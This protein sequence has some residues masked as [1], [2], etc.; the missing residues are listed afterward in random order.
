MT[1]IPKIYAFRIAL[2]WRHFANYFVLILIPVI[3][4]CSLA[5]FH[6]VRLIEKDAAK[7]NDVIMG[8]FTEQTDTAFNALKTN[9]IHMLSTSNL[10][11]LLK[12]AN[13]SRDNQQRTE[14]IHSLREQLNNLQSNELVSKAFLYFVNYDLMVDVETYTDKNYYFDFRYPLDPDERSTF[15]SNLTDKKMMDFIVTPASSIS[16]LMSYPFNTS[17]PEVYLVVTVNEERL[18]DQISISEKWVTGT[19]IVSNKGVVISQTS[20]LTNELKGLPKEALS[21]SNPSQ[22]LITKE[23]AISLVQSHFDENWYY[24]SM[25]DLATLMKPA[26][27]TRTI[28]WVFLIFFIVVGALVSYY[29]SRRL[30]RPIMEIKEGLKLHHATSDPIQNVGNEFD[31]I[32]RFSQLIMKENKQLSQQVNGMVP[33]VQ[34][35]FV[36]KMLLGEYRDALSIEFYAR[37]IDFPYNHQAE[38]TVLCISFHY[39]SPVYEQ[40]SETSKSFLKAELKEKI[41]QLMPFNSWLCQTKPGMIACVFHQDSSIYTGPDEAAQ[42]IKLVLSPYSQYFKTT[43]GIGKTV[44]VIEELHESYKQATL[45]LQRRG[46]H[47]EVEI[48]NSQNEGDTAQYESFLSVQ[49]VTRIMNQFKI[50]EYDKLL[51]SAFDMLEEGIRINATAIQAKYLCSDILNTWIHAVESERNDF[52]VPLY[53]SLFEKMNR[54]M[55]WN[56]LKNCF[57]EIHHV[58]FPEVETEDRGKKFT[59]ILAYIHEN[60]HSELSIEYFAG[61]LHMSSGHFSRTFKEEVG[62][63][64]VEYIAKYRLMKAKQ[65]LRETDMKIDDVADMVGYWGRNSFIRTFRKYEGITPA[66]Y[67][68]MQH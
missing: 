62:E 17:T 25:V 54:C 37:E 33:I 44:Q 63:K 4:A 10:K 14:M 15:L 13:D 12:I 36:T 56:D 40:L 48:C 18:R 51:Q 23:R 50:R 27:L 64:Y 52:N 35:H 2:F 3:V 22:F 39:D 57:Q 46:L 9:M 53:T 67:R 16:T 29:L 60:Y 43:I 28:S 68:S 38:R 34:E 31:I 6:V 41:V 8:R 1:T 20:L 49:D 45:V 61:S 5:Q 42:R 65:L 30:Y 58:L 55:T 66:K 7:L 32:K 26:H 11:S 19:A 47:S 59:D 24:T 21:S